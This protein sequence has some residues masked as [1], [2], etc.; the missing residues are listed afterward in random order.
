MRNYCKKFGVENFNCKTIHSALNL[1]IQGDEN[2]LGLSQKLGLSKKKPIKFNE[3][4]TVIID[5]IF[6][7]DP[8]LMTKIY[9]YFK[10]LQREINIIR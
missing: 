1:N 5:E 8:W 9:F 10:K 4:D 2:E 6:S 3:Y 7:I